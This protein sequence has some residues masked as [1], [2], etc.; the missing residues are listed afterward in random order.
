MVVETGFGWDHVGT[1]WFCF[2]RVQIE[3]MNPRTYSFYNPGANSG[4]EAF[5]AFRPHG[6]DHQRCSRLYGCQ[7]SDAFFQAALQRCQRLLQR[8]EKPL[9]LPCLTPTISWSSRGLDNRDDWVPAWLSP[10]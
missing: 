10:L 4:E 8:S 1:V 3:A 2:G 5:D 6:R 9:Q 7:E